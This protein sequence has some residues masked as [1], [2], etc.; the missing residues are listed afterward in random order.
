[1]DA[2][3]GVLCLGAVVSILLALQWAGT[4]RPWHSATI[5]VLFCVSGFLGALLLAWERTRL[6]DAI[7]P[8]RLFKRKTQ[9]GCTIEAFFIGMGLLNGTYYL[10]L[11]YQAQGHSA[12]RS[13]LDILPFMLSVV[14]ATIISGSVIKVTGCYWYFLVVSPALASV[15]AGMLYTLAVDA[16]SSQLIGYQILY[17][18]GLG[19]ALQNL[20]I[21]AQ[22]EWDD[23]K[24]MIPQA[25]TL[26]SFAQVAG[27]VVGIAAG[28]TIFAN[29]LRSKLS[30][31]APGL[32]AELKEAVEESV[33]SL[34]LVP[35]SYKSN[36]LMAYVSAVD[37]TF[38]LGIPAGALACF[39]AT[40]ISNRSVK[41]IGKLTPQNEANAT[42]EEEQKKTISSN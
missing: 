32:P 19:G 12:E 14:F 13:G 6:D 37:H 11:W 25:T 40:L 9:V 29:E 28:G 34:S 38:L 8:L 39:A 3:G 41:D 23:D 27:G 26:V 36:V 20:F 31:Y 7:I 15:G 30:S 18:A 42:R 35:D 24:A 2:C 1:M 17:G 16:S 22:A 33:S 5:I 21:A 4:A 10:P